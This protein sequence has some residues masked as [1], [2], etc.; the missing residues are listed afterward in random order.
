MIKK[1]N[2][3]FFLFHTEY[4]DQQVISPMSLVLICLQ[5]MENQFNFMEIV[6]IFGRTFFI[7][8]YA[9]PKLLWKGNL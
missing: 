7:E 6:W 5:K 8:K 4:S 9:V 2:K 1:V 3:L